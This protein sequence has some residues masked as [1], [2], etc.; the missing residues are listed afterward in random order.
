[1]KQIKLSLAAIFIITILHGVQ[2]Q[3]ILPDNLKSIST[4][5]LIEGTLV[6]IDIE[7]NM[8]VMKAKINEVDTLRLDNSAVIKAGPR[9]AA[10]KDLRP[11]KYVKANFELIKGEKHA[12]SISLFPA[13]S[14]LPD[15]TE[16][17]QNVL[18]AEGTIESVDPAGTMMVIKAPLA[19]EYIFSLDPAATI[20]SGGKHLRLK[21]LKPNNDIKVKYSEKGHRNVATSVV[22]EPK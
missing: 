2:S 8:F 14:F 22:A 13:N 17:G 7:Q 3:A 5:N 6:S 9:I 19:K 12:T 18:I 11:N 20:K 16:L 1:M 15:T 4:G 21:D 10:R